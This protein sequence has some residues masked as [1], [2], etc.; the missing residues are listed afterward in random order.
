MAVSPKL[1]NRSFGAR[2]S[3]VKVDARSS[4]PD[5]RSADFVQQ[6]APAEEVQ[7]CQ[8]EGSADCFGC[9]RPN[10]A[11]DGDRVALTRY[12]V[13]TRFSGAT[14][15]DQFAPVNIRVSG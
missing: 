4:L 9:P 10:E 11:A 2:R 13:A 1:R 14:T 6:E 7:C 3:L 12:G 5:E 15:V 8:P